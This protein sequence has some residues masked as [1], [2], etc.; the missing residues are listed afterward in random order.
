MPKPTAKPP[1][2]SLAEVK[3]LVLGLRD[4]LEACLAQLASLRT[5]CELAVNRPWLLRGAPTPSEELDREKEI[6]F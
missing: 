3:E 6:P 5:W 2:P 4:R 1:E